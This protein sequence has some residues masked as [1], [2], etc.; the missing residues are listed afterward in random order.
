MSVNAHRFGVRRASHA[1]PLRQQRL[2][3]LARLQRPVARN[4][5][6]R[7]QGCCLEDGL[8]L[9]EEVLSRQFRLHLHRGISYLAT[10]QLIRT[11]GDLIQLAVEEEG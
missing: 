3:V 1:Q 4:L 8:D 7:V 11:I 5:R 10:P 6:G 2:T 9:S